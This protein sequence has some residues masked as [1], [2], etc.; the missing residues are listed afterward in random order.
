RTSIGI[1]GDLNAYTQYSAAEAMTTA[2]A[3]PSG[4]MGAG[5]GMGMGIGMAQNA[6]GPWG[7]R[8]AAAAPQPAP[9]APPPP[10]VENVWHIAKNGQTS[11]PFS[12]AALGR[13]VTDGTLSRE[14]TVWTAG[15]DGWKPASDIRE[16]A[17][18]FTI[19]PPPM[20]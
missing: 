16:L 6:T 2:A 4:A 7:A 13:M 10:P 3:N 15:Q 12:R 20:S 1:V 8:A 5:I 9:I 19:L 17:T 11:G 14:T 18:L